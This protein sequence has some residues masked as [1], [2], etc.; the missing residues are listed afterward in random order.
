LIKNVTENLNAYEPTQA[1]RAIED[2]VDAQLSNWYVRLG[3]RRFWRSESDSDKQAAYETLFECLETVS[4]LMS[5]VAPFFAEWLYRN[6]NAASFEGVASV[7]T[8]NWP[9]TN[10]ALI[11]VDL[12]ERMELAQRY[13]S[14]ILALRKKVNIKVRQPLQK[15]SIP[16]IDKD[17]PER[18]QLVAD[19]IKAETNI[20]EIELLAADNDFIRKKAKANDSGRAW[21]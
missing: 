12:E 8:S 5:P 17:M 11:D 19:I 16:A 6:L 10:T 9:A 13:C 1:G 14:M 2:F 4:Q 18:I 7:H 15:V 21:T 3:R 20:K